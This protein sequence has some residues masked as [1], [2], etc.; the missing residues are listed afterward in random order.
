MANK[1]F[2]WKGPHT[3]ADVWSEPHG[4]DVTLIFSGQ[5]VP[6]REIPV[7]LPEENSQVA[8]WIAFKLVEEKPAEE[9]PAGRT[10]PGAKPNGT[11][12]NPIG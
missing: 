12:E 2:I 8:S 1:T 5:L 3:A 4:P 10:K 9:K 11:E 6:D 7:P